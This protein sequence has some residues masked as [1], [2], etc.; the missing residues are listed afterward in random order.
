MKDRM[1]KVCDHCYNELKKRGEK[2]VLKY[3]WISY[4]KN[5]KLSL[6]HESHAADFDLKWIRT[7]KPPPPFF[8]SIKKFNHTLNPSV[9]YI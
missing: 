4:I 8:L 3:I 7:V 6:H 5:F 9:I 2:N 1:A